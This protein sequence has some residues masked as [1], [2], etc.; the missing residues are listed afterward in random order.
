M[1]GPGRFDLLQRHLVVSDHPQL[2]RRVDLAEP[3]HQV[4]GERVVIVDQK[5]HEQNRLSR[6]QRPQSLA[7][8]NHPYFLDR[9]VPISRPEEK[10][11]RNARAYG[12]GA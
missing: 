4:V 5:D 11:P 9:N 1:R 2:D 3:L 6:R 12:P 10:Q 7:N 8:R